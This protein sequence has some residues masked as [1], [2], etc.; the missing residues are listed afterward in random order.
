MENKETSPQ[1]NNTL[2][3]ALIQPSHEETAIITDKNKTEKDLSNEVL[4]FSINQDSK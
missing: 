1:A 4:Y 2:N 3:D